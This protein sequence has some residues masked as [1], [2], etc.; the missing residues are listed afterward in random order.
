MNKARNRDFRSEIIKLHLRR[1]LRGK[2]VWDR[3]KILQMKYHLTMYRRE[4]ELQIINNKKN[5]IN[6]TN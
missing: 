3:L 5:E 6:E 2:T 1:K 4:M